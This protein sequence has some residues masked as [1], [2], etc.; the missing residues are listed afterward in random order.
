MSVGYTEKDRRQAVQTVLDYQAQG[1]D[2]RDAINLVSSEMGC[3]VPIIVRWMEKWDLATHVWKSNIHVSSLRY[4]NQCLKRENKELL[5]CMSYL[6]VQQLNFARILA[7]QKIREGD[8]LD[9]ND[10]ADKPRFH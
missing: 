6:A 10:Q 2:R 8:E 1:K 4:Q 9:L 5:K 3:T 7:T